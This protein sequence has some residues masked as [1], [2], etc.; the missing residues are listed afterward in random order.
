MTMANFSN[1]WKENCTIL[2][3]MTKELEI[4]FKY[5]KFNKYFHFTAWMKQRQKG[6]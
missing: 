2:S 5:F 3:D 4:Y 1:F 6:I